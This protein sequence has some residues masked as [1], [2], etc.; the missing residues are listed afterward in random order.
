MAKTFVGIGFGP[1]QSGLFLLEAY[2]SGNF[3]RFVVSEVSTT[4]VEA[5]R[6][7]GGT[8]AINIA[9]TSG[10]RTSRVQGLEIL[11]PNDR[12]DHTKLVSAIAVADELATALP[13]VRFFDHGAP[14]PADLLAQGFQS[15]LKS[16][17]ETPTVVYAAE[18]HNHA[19]ELLKERVLNKL[20][21]NERTQLEELVHFSNTV[22]GKM[23]GVVTDTQQIRREGLV[24]HTV[25]SD[26]AVL[27]EQFNRILIDRIMLPGFRRG[28]DV[29]EEKRDLLPFEEAKLYGHNAAH[30]LLGFLAHLQGASYMSETR[31]GDLLPLVKHAFLEESGQALCQ[32]HHG[33]DPL[34]TESGWEAYV[35]DLLLRM[36]N[37]FLQDRVDRVIRDPQRKLGWDDRLIGTMR[38][39]L[40]YGVSPQIYALGAAAA[41]KLL[42]ADQ[43]YRSTDS[44]LTELWNGSGNSPKLRDTIVQLIN[45]A[46]FELPSKVRFID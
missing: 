15:K 1:I 32:R 39:A 4:L 22:I 23:S 24:P 45:G 33:I 16:G 34:F 13:S 38:L 25:R 3:D 9:E 27:V 8:Y 26:Y 5:V 29:F 44:V 35:Q 42:L 43:T 41:L 2:R 7:S 21:P 12:A 36:T 40:R 28:L 46:F 37:P 19:A 31:H 6:S 18:N 14:S 30:A 17:N 11:N 20:L 10:I